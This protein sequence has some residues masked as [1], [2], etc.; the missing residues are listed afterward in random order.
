MAHKSTN[1]LGVAVVAAMAGALAAL[2]FAPKSGEELRGDI[3]DKAKRTKDMTEDK[4]DAAKD[5]AYTAKDKVREK[6]ASAP[7]DTDSEALDEYG[8]W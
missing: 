2:L 5:K 6:M 1:I 3:K 8:R 4:I 7:L